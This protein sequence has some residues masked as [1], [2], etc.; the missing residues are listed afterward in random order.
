M[1]PSIVA[2][3]VVVSSCLASSAASAQY[4]EVPRPLPVPVAGAGAGGDVFTA[5]VQIG[6]RLF[7]AGPFTHLAES[8]G[9]AVV[10]TVLGTPVPNGFPALRPSPAAATSAP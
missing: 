3:V 8:A 6:R 4:A 10:T 5:A 9:G 1:Q 2:A 7:V